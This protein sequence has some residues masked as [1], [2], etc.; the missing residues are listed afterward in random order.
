ME[1][2]PIGG[3]WDLRNHWKTK[4]V[5]GL[6]NHGKIKVFRRFQ[7][8][9][10]MHLFLHL[11]FKGIKQ[12]MKSIC[13]CIYIYIYVTLCTWLHTHLFIYLCMYG[14][15]C[16]C[17]VMY[18]CVSIIIS[19]NAFCNTPA[20]HRGRG[21]SGK[22]YWWLK[23]SCNVSASRQRRSSLQGLGSVP[24]LSG[25]LMLSRRFV[26]QC[27]QWPLCNASISEPF[28]DTQVVN[29]NWGL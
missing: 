15:S 6:R 10:K 24:V 13:M 12:M 5:G 29:V 4:V 11:F 20:P 17:T 8:P 3:K 7:M 28:R 16:V 18:S 23:R 21:R 2:P 27:T 22:Y 19:M 1:P 25:G 26:Y 14:C 9:C